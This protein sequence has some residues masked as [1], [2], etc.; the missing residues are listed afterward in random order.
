MEANTGTRRMETAREASRATTTV[1]AMSS[2]IIPMTPRSFLKI[3][4]GRNTETEVR[5]DPVIAPITS[6]VPSSAEECGSAPF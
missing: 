4:R 5:I 3:S 2:N 6:W 1:K